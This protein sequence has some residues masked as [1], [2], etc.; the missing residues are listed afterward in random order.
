MISAVESMPSFTAS[1]PRSPRTASIWAATNGGGRLYTPLTPTEFC[2]VTAV[3][4]DIPNTR[5]A[6]NVLRSAWMPAPPPESEPAMVSAFG[7]RITSG[8]IR[9]PIYMGASTWPPYPHPLGR[10]RRSR[11]RPRL[12]R[13]NDDGELAAHAGGGEALSMDGGGGAHDLLELLGELA[14]D[15]DLP[16][17]EDLRDRLQRGQDAMRR[18]VEDH[19]RVELAKRGEAVDAPPGL[20]RQGAVEN[21]S[22]RP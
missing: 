21:G 8:S 1:A 5:N 3:R 18:L 4:T 15:D 6:E 22:P 2:A 20:D 12:P 14:A 7:T 19:R 13:G 9:P 10:P 16:L 17:A 11:G